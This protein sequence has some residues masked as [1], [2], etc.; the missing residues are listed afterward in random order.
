[1]GLF[2]SSMGSRI[3]LK[4]WHLKVPGGELHEGLDSAE[5]RAYLEAETDVAEF[6]VRSRSDRNWLPVVQHPQWAQFLT[7]RQRDHVLGCMLP[8]AK[9]GAGP[10]PVEENCNGNIDMK[11]LGLAD[12]MAEGSLSS[13]LLEMDAQVPLDKAPEEV[14]R[15]EDIYAL[16]AR[17]EGQSLARAHYRGLPRK[18]VSRMRRLITALLFW[19]M[20]YFVICFLLVFIFTLP[21]TE[22][23]LFGYC[24][25]I[26][27]VLMFTPISGASFWL[28]LGLLNSTLYWMTMVISG[29]L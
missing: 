11:T 21:Q 18:R 20:A 25:Y 28:G 12:N 5:V 24:N 23:N 29:N 14:F 16:N 15:V 4:M 13:R 17:C 10:V 7:A 9:A 2:Q 22:G 6:Q 26:L 3:Q 1:M 19:N 27:T 8:D